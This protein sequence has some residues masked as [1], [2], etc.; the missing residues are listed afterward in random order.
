M[1]KVLKLRNRFLV[2]ENFMM[3]FCLFFLKEDWIERACCNLQGGSSFYSVI[4]SSR[5]NFF[6][7]S[8]Q[9]DFK[10]KSLSTSV[11][12]LSEILSHLIFALVIEF[13]S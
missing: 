9:N 7:Q 1:L 6:K 10:E 4:G 11:L 12:F 13:S 8:V 2:H 3:K 5:T